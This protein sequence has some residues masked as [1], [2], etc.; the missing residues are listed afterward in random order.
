MK[1][2][3]AAVAAG[4]TPAFWINLVD[5]AAADGRNPDLKDAVDEAYTN[6]TFGSGRMEYGGVKLRS[7]ARPEQRNV[8][9]PRMYSLIQGMQAMLFHRRPKF[10]VKPY[11]GRLEKMAQDFERLLGVM[12]PRFVSDKELR[13]QIND[14]AKHG[15]S[16]G[17]LGF[18]FDDDEE[19]ARSAE[20]RRVARMLKES[21]VAQIAPVESLAS[22][23]EPVVPPAEN[24]VEPETWSGDARDRVRKPSFRRL[25]TDDVTYD[26]DA[27]TYHDL[28]W[29]D[30]RSYIPLDALKADPFFKGADTIRVFCK[31]ERGRWKP[32]TETPAEYPQ[33]AGGQMS[34][35]SYKY[36]EHH[37]TAVKRPG[38]E[39]DVLQYC[40]GQD[41]FGRVQKAPY[42]F[43]NP[44]VTLA[45]NDD[46]D[47]M[48]VVSDAELL[49]PGVVEEASLRTRLKDHWSR[50]PN[51]CLMVDEAVF[52]NSSNRSAIDVQRV[53]SFLPV[54]R[55]SEQAQTPLSNY[56]FP[57]P[58]NAAINEAYQH[59]QLL[60]QDFEAVT[61]LGPNQQLRAMKSETSSFEAQE[62]ARNAKARGIEKQEAV[63]DYCAQVGHR[64]LMLAAQF[65]DAERV[66]EYVSG[67]AVSRWKT[68]EF[69]P[70]DVQDGLG[71][72]V[73]RGSMRPQSDERR[74]QVLNSLMQAGLGNPAFAAT[75][76]LSEILNR[77]LEIEGIL[78]G[79]ALVNQ[80]VDFGQM[81]MAM[82][83]MQLAGAA[84]SKAAPAQQ[85]NATPGPSA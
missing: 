61:G 76:N 6:R 5:A 62:V 29:V 7:K 56:V 27:R 8:R 11:A 24:P 70:G 33:I 53:A 85:S 84:P 1:K 4:E 42:W 69:N 22:T 52:N 50:K 77:S 13:W 44:F 67:E 12:W 37:Y 68:Y 35:D 80:G 82:M 41:G 74:A 32:V 18:E 46:G 51:D 58:R 30:L 57:I 64:L 10:F 23:V 78:D 65:F 59:L 66:A 19:R 16:W 40:R 63:E 36:V 47:S 79:S 26:P 72:T 34:S 55:P 31:M 2:K 15:R 43:G 25:P 54:R 75:L 9:P 38:G 45:W 73:E 83:Q 49:L 39:W 48:D 3:K 60:N 14:T 71:V 17:L 28:R 81:V 20:R 21:S